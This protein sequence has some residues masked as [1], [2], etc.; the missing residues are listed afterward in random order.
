MESRQ[1]VRFQAWEFPAVVAYISQFQ[2]GRLGRKKQNGELII[3]NFE[4]GVCIEQAD[5]P[6]EH[7]LEFD[8]VNNAA[9]STDKMQ[10]SSRFITW[11]QA[12]WD[13]K[14]ILVECKSERDVDGQIISRNEPLAITQWKMSAGGLR[15][16][17][18]PWNDE[19]K[20]PVS[21]LLRCE[22]E[23]LNVVVFDA[24]GLAERENSFPDEVDESEVQAL[25]DKLLFEQYGG[26]AV[27]DA[28]SDSGA[29]EEGENS[30]LEGSVESQSGQNDSYAVEAFVIARRHLQVVDNWACQARQ[31]KLVAGK[32]NWE[33]LYRDGRLLMG[34]FNRQAAL[35][36]NDETGARLAAEELALRLKYFA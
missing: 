35:H 26:K 13:G 2:Q 17:Q 9:I 4:L 32:S 31:A 34:A 21:V 20:Q 18:I 6:F 15:T 10:R 36:R 14:V 29:I 24:R 33:T 30:N 19:M 12:T 8:D 5:W 28:E 25:R 11:A 22:S 27:T 23:E 7:L 3:E 16:A 1:D